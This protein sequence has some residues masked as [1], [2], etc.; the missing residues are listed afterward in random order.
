[1]NKLRIKVCGM[2]D[3][4]NIRE[5]AELNPDYMGFIFYPQSPRFIGEQFQVP[6][7]LSVAIRSVGV[8]VNENTPAI[9]D[10]AKTHKLSMIQLHGDETV[11]QCSELKRNG[12]DVIK[13]FSVDSWFDFSA[14]N[15]YKHVVDYFMFDTKG[16]YYGG[17]A[18]AFDWGILK[19]YDQEVPFILSGGLHP[20]NVK[21]VLNLK[22]M[23][24]HAVD[25]NSGVE[26]SPGLKD[27]GKVREIITNLKL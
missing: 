9:L 15:P 22:G 20:D 11:D 8:F 25:V 16:K 10:K 24:I 27:I 17:N 1:M 18:R 21:E 14:V 7:D 3:P 26:V 5:V 19:R 4:E 6:D 2:R 12:L 13:V 23:N